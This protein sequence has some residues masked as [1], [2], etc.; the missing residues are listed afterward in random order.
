MNLLMGFIKADSGS[1]YINGQDINN[2]NINTIRNSIALLSQ[3][4]I[5]LQRSIGE[6]I[7]YH[8][9]SADNIKIQSVLQKSKVENFI[10]KLLDGF[11]D[12]LTDSGSNF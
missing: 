8:A 12:M 3:E 10:S 1:I 11:S 4:S 6:N 2:Y 5:L 9:K 7:L